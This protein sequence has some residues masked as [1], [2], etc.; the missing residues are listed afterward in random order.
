LRRLVVLILVLLFVSCQSAPDHD[1]PTVD[2]TI[3]RLRGEFEELRKLNK[4]RARQ[5]FR[6]GFTLGAVL[7]PGKTSE[8]LRILARTCTQACDAYGEEPTLEDNR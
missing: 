5:C 6:C 3:Q 2:S 7:I 1:N 4:Q 8:Q